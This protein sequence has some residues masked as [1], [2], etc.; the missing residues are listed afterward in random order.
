MLPAGYTRRQA[1]MGVVLDPPIF[2]LDGDTW[3]SALDSPESFPASNKAVIRYVGAAVD[4]ED[5]P[6]SDGE[7]IELTIVQPME[8]AAFDYLLPGQKQP[9]LSY[10]L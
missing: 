2:R 9:L 7:I 5:D 3:V 10:L 6:D 1:K 8:P 4:R